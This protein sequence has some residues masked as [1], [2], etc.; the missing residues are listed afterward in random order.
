MSLYCEIPLM[1]LLWA[2]WPRNNGTSVIHA[3]TAH[4]VPQ[5]AT[6]EREP[7]LGTT[8]RRRHGWWD[9]VD[10]KTVDL[11]AEEYE[12]EEQGEEVIQ[13]KTWRSQFKRIVNW[14]A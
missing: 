10:V 6:D 11:H 12:E 5:P 4:L 1:L 8:T 3:S 14:I 9:W 13:T 7:L 2:L